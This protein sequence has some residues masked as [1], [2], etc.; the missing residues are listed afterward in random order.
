MNKINR[1][2]MRISE[3]VSS[4]KFPD[5]LA[6]RIDRVL[7]DIPPGGICYSQRKRL[8]GILKYAVKHCSYY[9]S[10]GIS[11]STPEDVEKFPVLDKKTIKN[12]FD[13]FL[14]DDIDRMNYYVSHTGGSTGEPLELYNSPGID[15]LFQNKLW[16]RY[17]YKDGDIILAMDG[18]KLPTEAIGRGEYLYKK[19]SSQLPYGGYGLSSLYLTDDN[20][21][22]YCRALCALKP[23]FIRGYPSFVYRIANYI[24]EEGIKLDFKLKAV[25][26]T[27]ESS[28]TYQHDLIRSVFNTKVFMQ[29]GHTEACVFGYTFDDTLRYKIEPLY[30]YVEV[31]TAEGQAAKEGEMGEV[32]VTT[33][34]NRVMPLIRYRTGDQAIYGG[35]GKDGIILN[36]VLGRTQD[37]I[38]NVD[39]EK[40]LL[41]ALIFAQHFDALGNIIRW[42]IE[43]SEIGTVLIHIVK[44]DTFTEKDETEIKNLFWNLGKVHVVFDYENGIQLTQRGKSLM[45]VQHIQ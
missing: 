15:D 30:G 3:L 27:S 35:K 12:N 4:G 5:M 19:N 10:L 17:G 39:G 11:V 6:N 8:V 18:T 26:L 23:D 31:L 24:Y 20:I 21:G 7:T 34:H 13:G 14:S 32:V 33:L 41:T 44:R 37:Y 42:Q 2:F 40:V 36:K 29:Y 28:F 25:E 45:L 1:L 22:D 16:R 38:I 9:K 43:Q